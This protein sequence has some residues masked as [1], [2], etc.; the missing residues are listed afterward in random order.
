MYVIDVAFFFADSHQHGHQ[1]CI[2]LFKKTAKQQQ[3]QQQQQKIFYIKLTEVKITTISF[4]KLFNTL[5]E[6]RTTY[7]PSSCFPKTKFKKELFNAEKLQ[8][9]TKLVSCAV[10]AIFVMRCCLKLCNIFVHL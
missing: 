4:R 8:A 5:E 7:L 1:I 3:Q 9:K 6:K 2:Y 10:F